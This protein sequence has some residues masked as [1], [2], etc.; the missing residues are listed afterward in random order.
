[1]VYHPPPPFQVEEI[2]VNLEGMRGKSSLSKHPLIWSCLLGTILDTKRE[3][4]LEYELCALMCT[5][6]KAVPVHEKTL[7]IFFL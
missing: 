5:A 1:M 3:V 4:Q 6:K 2:T 7:C